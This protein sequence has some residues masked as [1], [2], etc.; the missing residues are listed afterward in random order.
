VRGIAA[1]EDVPE[2]G[3]LAVGEVLLTR[4]GGAVAAFHNR[5]PHAGFSL[6]KSDGALIVQERL[7]LVCPV[8]GA[9]F[10]LHDGACAGG[11]CNGEGLSPIT[12]TVR[13]GVI[14]AAV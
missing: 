8:H 12:I 6:V 14:Y 3:A 2:G 9:S 13:D 4:V 10:S 5:C 7:Y 11:P 1:V